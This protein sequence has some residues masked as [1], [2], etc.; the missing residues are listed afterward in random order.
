[1]EHLLVQALQS[2]PDVA[3]LLALYEGQPAIFCQQAPGAGSPGWERT[4][5]HTKQHHLPKFIRH[6]VL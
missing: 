1:M 3:G 6:Y 5:N 2:S 4:V